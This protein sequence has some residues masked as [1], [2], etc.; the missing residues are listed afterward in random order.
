MNRRELLQKT[1]VFGLAAAVS[2]SSA[3]AEGAHNLHSEKERSGLNPL[4]PPTEGSIPVAF[5]VSEGAVIIDFCG[6]WE[7][8]HDVYVPGRKDDPFR[9]YTVAE[10]TNPIHASGGMKIIPD[11]TLEMAPAPKVIVIPAQNGKSDAML[12]WIRK[13]TKNTDV[14]MSVCTG[15]FLLAETGLLAGRAAT[16]FHGAF[17]DFAR[18]FPDIRLKRGARF[19]ED[20]N[21]ASAGGLSS[22]I[23][24]ALRVVERYH[25]R[26][27]A[28]NTAYVMEYQGQGWMNPDSNNVYTKVR[29]STDEHPIC[30]V[31]DMDVDRA[32]ALSSVYK[33][34]TYY[35]CMPGH[36]EEFDAAP[37]KF[38]K[39]S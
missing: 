26:E 11:Y 34:K 8:F 32:T 36:K 19:V 29:A 28:K 24:L 31:C 39:T 16:T 17:S 9:L 3:D 35:F 21:L 10:T 13:S 33:G 38:V 5:L 6:P 18:Q 30:P 37:E 20:G 27:V 4:I 23:D 25:G 12:Q 2:F 7:V 22:G 14:T 15:A 1:A